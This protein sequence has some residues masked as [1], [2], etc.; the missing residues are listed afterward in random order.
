MIPGTPSI[1]QFLLSELNEG[2]TVGLNGLTYSLADAQSLELDLK[3]KGIGVNSDLSLIDPIWSDRPAVPEAPIFEMPVALS[4]KSSEDKIEEINRMLHQA[5]ADCTILSALDE[6]AWTCNIRG[7]DV[8]YN[9]VAVSYAF[10]SDKECVL[11]INPKKVPAEIAEHLKKEG[12]I[13][14]DYGKVFDYLK[15]L[16][17]NVRVFMDRSKTNMAIYNAL[18]KGATVIDGISPANHL[19]SIK[20]ETEIKG[21]RNAVVKDGIALS[22]WKR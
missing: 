9:P 6:V 12:W 14:A 20:N 18:P 5:G 13:L 10:V 16:P 1:A 15:R 21:F 17:E 7:T 19:K 22:G 2:D 8:S 11:F 3:K 4:G